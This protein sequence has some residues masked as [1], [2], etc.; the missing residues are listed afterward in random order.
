[1]KKI[2]MDMIADIIS[3]LCCVATTTLM[4]LKLCGVINRS[5]DVI[6]IPI[7]IAFVLFALLLILTVIVKQIIAKKGN[8]E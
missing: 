5:W 6:I 7:W 2:T 1:M 4:I 8:K 3:I